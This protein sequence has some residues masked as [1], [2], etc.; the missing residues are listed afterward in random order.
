M[1]LLNLHQNT[2]DRGQMHCEYKDKVELQKLEKLQTPPPPTPTSPSPPSQR[3]KSW[4]VR[5]P[6]TGFC[7]WRHFN[8]ANLDDNYSVLYLSG[9]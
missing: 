4:H 1:H 2:R 9:I 7:S 5:M 8:E 3:R 6:I